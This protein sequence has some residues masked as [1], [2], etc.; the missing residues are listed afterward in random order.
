MIVMPSQ[1][2]FNIGLLIA[3]VGLIDTLL[4]IDDTYSDGGVCSDTESYLLGFIV[5]CGTVL[6]SE[7]AKFLGVPLAVLGFLF[8]ASIFFLFVMEQ[9]SI[10]YRDLINKYLLPAGA[11]VGILASA[12]FVWIQIVILER[13]CIYCMGSAVT[14]TLLFLFI[15][16]TRVFFK[17]K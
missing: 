15:F 10:D 16:Y 5:D 8:Y 7:Y 14:S 12:Y 13:I 17:R 2:K 6:R 1:K 3:S 11:V 4:L 9:K